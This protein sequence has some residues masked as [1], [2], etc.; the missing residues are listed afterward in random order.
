MDI[1]QL[2]EVLK[3]AKDVVS[4]QISSP[5]DPFAPWIDLMKAILPALATAG[6]AWLAMNKSHENSE[7][8][9][10]RQSE[11]FR[12]GIEQQVRS[13][14]LNAQLATK[15]E[16]EKDL[17][18]EIRELSSKFIQHAQETLQT[19]LESTNFVAYVKT[20]PKELQSKTLDEKKEQYADVYSDA[21][22][23]LRTVWMHLMTYIDPEADKDMYFALKE[24]FNAAT[25][26]K[27]KGEALGAAVVQCSL[28]CRRFIKVKHDEIAK[29]AETIL[30][31]ELK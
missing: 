1:I 26:S 13:L 20:L 21:S 27:D 29:L 22:K 2:L 17:C 24:A 14:K 23:K 30:N 3:P 25:T 6:V 4:V 10:E 28:E 12:A 11:Q 16:L 9:L 15:I 8:N 5:K 7:K 19:R 18:R 31:D